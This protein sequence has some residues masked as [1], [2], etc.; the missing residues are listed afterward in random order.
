MKN[1]SGITISLFA[2]SQ[3]PEILR[4]LR[5]LIA[6]KSD[7]DASCQTREEGGSDGSSGWVTNRSSQPPRPRMRPPATPQ[8]L[9]SP[10]PGGD[11]RSLEQRRRVV[12]TCLGFA[13]G[14]VEVHLHRDLLRR[15]RHRKLASGK[16]PDVRE[17]VKAEPGQLRVYEL[18][19]MRED[20]SNLY[21]S[22][23]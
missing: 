15:K 10:R 20:V 18:V 23:P 14:H 19:D 3:R 8:S 7:D 2:S 9:M 12:L 21:L 5:D 22:N 4:C 1:A 16:I 11:S 13:D 17:N 6:V